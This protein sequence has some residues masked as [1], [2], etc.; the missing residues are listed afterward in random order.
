MSKYE[1]REVRITPELPENVFI[2]DQ[3]TLSKTIEKIPANKSVTVNFQFKIEKNAEE[4][5]FSLPLNFKYKNVYRNDFADEK[6]YV[7]IKINNDNLP[8]QLV[9]RD[10]K[11]NPSIVKSGENFSV[12]FDVWNMGTIEAKNVTID[13]DSGENFFILDNVTK[14][15]LFELRGLNNREISYNLKGK[16]DLESGT[17]PVTISLEHEDAAKTDYTLYVTVE[18]EEEEEEDDND[19]YHRKC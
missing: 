3:M 15:Y 7:Y 9:V 13:I 1:A 6:K 10:G 16:K 2:V 17:Y 4:K 8:P 14:Q 19:D 11:T 18:G 12:A 5:T